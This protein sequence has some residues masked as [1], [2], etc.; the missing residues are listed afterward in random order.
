MFSYLGIIYKFANFWLKVTFPGV[1]VVVANGVRL[2]GLRM[3]RLVLIPRCH[4][5][6][7]L[8]PTRMYIMYIWNFGTG[9]SLTLELKTICRKLSYQIVHF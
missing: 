4:R 7:H 9:P 1:C 8:A 6:S 5:A 3:G 2:S